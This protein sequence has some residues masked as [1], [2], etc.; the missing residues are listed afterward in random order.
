MGFYRD[1]DRGVGDD[2][3]VVTVARTSL[4]MVGP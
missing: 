4:V 2:G 3:F 1:Y